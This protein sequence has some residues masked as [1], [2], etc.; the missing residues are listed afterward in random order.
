MSL[1]SEPTI[2]RPNMDGGSS[3][4]CFIDSFLN[5]AVHNRFPKA[6]NDGLIELVTPND[7]FY[8]LPT[9]RTTMG[10]NLERMR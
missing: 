7:N 9:D 1:S 6:M 10:D 8:P 5:T 3:S 2:S 4:I